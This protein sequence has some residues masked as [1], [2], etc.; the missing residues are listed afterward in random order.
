MIDLLIE[1]ASIVTMD[2]ARP[3]ASRLGIWQGRVFGLDDDLAG[4]TG[5]ATVD[6]G[7]RT[8]VPGF[9][10]AH[11]HLVWAGQAERATDLRGAADVAEVLAR[12]EATALAAPPGAWV[13]AVGY[14]QRPLG[15]HLTRHDLDPVA[16]GRR[17]LLV[18]T[19][20]HGQLVDSATLAAVTEPAGGWPDG[21]VTDAAG[22]PTGLFL[23]ESVDLVAAL[24]VP[25][26]QAELVE[27]VAAGAARCASQ[28]VTAVAEAG[29]GGGLTGRSRVEA[30]AYR[31]ALASGR[32]PVRVRLMVAWNALQHV[33]GHPDDGDTATLVPGLA[34]GF[35]DDRVAL[36]AVKAWLDGGMMARTA[37]LTEPY[38]V[39]PTTAGALTPD[40]AAISATAVAAHAGG[41]QLA[42]HAI[43]DRA[44]DAALDIVEQ[45]RSAAPRSDARPRIEHAGLVR[46][47]QLARMADLGVTAVVQP[48]FLTE[49]GDD[50]ARIVG[51]GRAGWLY[52]GR[53]F[54][55]AGVPLAGS[56]D[57]PVA[58]GAPL[59]A[60]EFMVTR[61]SSSG[62]VIGPDEALTVDQALH[63]Y[64]AGAAR[65][66]GLDEVAGTLTPGR[67][68]DLVVL[69]ADPRAVA[70]DTIADIGIVTTVLA[71]VPTHGAWPG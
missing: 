6:L 22:V 69:D 15:R 49:F 32:L 1:N 37:A 26:A 50:Y 52:R 45:A 13:D 27:A 14:D 24:R 44:V 41:W 39:Q 67:A 58:D 63:A 28:G 59:A 4:V 68:A 54:L 55:D 5:R 30:A 20:G 7:G 56:S 71:G 64:T 35:G 31:S 2:P 43:G 10:D 70:P 47:D 62:A 53:G 61:R 36:G 40:L 12:L 33:T 25:Y 19:S 16:H 60:I 8:V 66:C 3:T 9:V 65:A 57:R 11:V 18:H 42:L 23:E 48:R 21:V 46:P 34:T 29:I 38:L 17:L 51:E